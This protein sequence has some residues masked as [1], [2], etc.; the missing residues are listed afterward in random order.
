MSPQPATAAK[1]LVV[2]DNPTG[3]F[4]ISEL[5]RERF[6]QS[7]ILETDNVG[8]AIALLARE[9][10]AAIVC[11]RGD[12][13]DDAELVRD[14]RRMRPV[15]PIVG[16]SDAP[17]VAPVISAGAN[18]FARYGAWATIA[19]AVSRVLEP[20]PP[21]PV[22]ATP[23]E[24]GP[25]APELTVVVAHNDD[26]VRSHVRHHIGGRPGA[27]TIVGEAEN[28]VDA[29]QLVRSAQPDLAVVDIGMLGYAGIDGLAPLGALACVTQFAYLLVTG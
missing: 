11:H 3:R 24:A 18:E 9:T 12:D 21:E 8:E 27:A 5:L 10:V 14:L 25:A 20:H 16:T 29:L 15:V 4:V 13:C 19:D 28:G 17:R 23:L 2:D 7:I 1:L 22:V 26:A 6:P